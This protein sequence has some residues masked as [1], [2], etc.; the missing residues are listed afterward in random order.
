[1]LAIFGQARLIRKLDG[2]LELRGG[3][4]K[5][6][7]AAREWMHTFMRRADAGPQTRGAS[8]IV[9]ADGTFALQ[10]ANQTG[11]GATGPTLKKGSWMRMAVVG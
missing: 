4:E 11:G 7:A 8:P 2:R 5:D 10:W 1:M 6:R 3:S 9:S